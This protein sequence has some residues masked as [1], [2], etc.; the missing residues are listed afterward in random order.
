MHLQIKDRFKD[1]KDQCTHIPNGLS[2]R[3]Q[4]D[5]KEHGTQGKI[6]VVLGEKLAGKS[7]INGN[8]HK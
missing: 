7:E 2:E 6:N 5:H 1:Q 3:R 4:A 8:Q